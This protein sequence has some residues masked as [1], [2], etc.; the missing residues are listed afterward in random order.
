MISS[1]WRKEYSKDKENYRSK[2]NTTTTIL[3]FPLTSVV[4]PFP[5][6]QV[7]RFKII[8]SILPMCTLLSLKN[9]SSASTIF[10]LSTNLST[11]GIFLKLEAFHLK[12]Q[13]WKMCIQRCWSTSCLVTPLIKNLKLQGSIFWHWRWKTLFFLLILLQVDPSSSLLENKY[14][15]TK[16]VLSWH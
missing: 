6:A 14:M 10:W 8:S 11:L 3:F 5:E 16:K 1:K 13:R 4:L 9:N 2:W 7:N 15:L 12:Y